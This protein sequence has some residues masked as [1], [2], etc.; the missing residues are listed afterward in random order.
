MKSFNGVKIGNSLFVLQTQM[1]ALKGRFYYYG[2]GRGGPAVRAIA[3][4]SPA[5]APEGKRQTPVT[6]SIKKHP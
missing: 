4:R 2:D 1:N 5:E 6:C 3:K